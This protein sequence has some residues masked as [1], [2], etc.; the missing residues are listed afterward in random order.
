MP[1]FLFECLSVFT[2]LA[3]T[4]RLACV[5]REM[6]ACSHHSV[7]FLFVAC[8]CCVLLALLPIRLAKHAADL[9]FLCLLLI[10]LWRVVQQ[11]RLLML[12]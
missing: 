12:I 9:V 7:C 2:R 11:I 6:D 8:I 3:L 10:C 4:R 5:A 1:A